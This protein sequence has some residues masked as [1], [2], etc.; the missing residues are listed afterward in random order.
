MTRRR[1]CT[2]AR[3]V[4]ACLR[5]TPWRDHRG[6]HSVPRYRASA[7]RCPSRY[8]VQ[9]VL[10]S[11]GRA[12]VSSFCS[13]VLVLEARRHQQ[14]AASAARR[15]GD[16][17]VYP[18][19]ARGPPASLVAR[20]ARRKDGLLDRLIADESPRLTANGLVERV[21][22]AH[23]GRDGPS[24]VGGCRT[25]GRSPFGTYGASPNR[26][27]ASLKRREASTAR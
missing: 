8:A 5:D 20:R 9:K 3:E 7:S 17:L 19:E 18:H 23:F 24:A 16:T 11:L 25:Q 6:D 4:T 1:R 26:H 14:I 15:R 22:V 10:R 13:V 12:R 21:R 2:Q 27:A